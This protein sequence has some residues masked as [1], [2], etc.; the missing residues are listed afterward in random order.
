MMYPEWHLAPRKTELHS[1]LEALLS[2]LSKPLSNDEISAEVVEI[3]GYDD[4]DLV[5]QIIGHRVV[6]RQEVGSENRLTI[7]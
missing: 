5:F 3:I 2:A 4:I 6:L 7:Q 1:L